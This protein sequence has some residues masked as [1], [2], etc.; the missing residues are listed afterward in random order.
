MQHYARNAAVV[1]SPRRRRRRD[2]TRHFCRV[3]L[4]AQE[5]NALRISFGDRD[6]HGTDR[7]PD[8][9]QSVAVR[10]DQKVRNLH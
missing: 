9:W 6:G 8:E 1:T 10:L 5:T 7:L 4:A 2:V 3:K